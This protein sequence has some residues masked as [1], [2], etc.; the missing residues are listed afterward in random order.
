M[1]SSSLVI[2]SLAFHGALAAG[3]GA[4]RQDAARRS[5]TAISMAE[6]KPKP[7]PKHDTPPPKTPDPP[8]DDHRLKAKAAPPREAKATDAPPPKST[9]PQ[10]AG[11]P[12]G[13]PDFGLSLSGGVGPGGLAIPDGP[14]R[15]AVEAPKAAAPRAPAAQ[16]PVVDDCTEAVVKPKPIN[17]PQPAYTEA[18]RGAG[19][20]GKVRVE[21]TVDAQGAV[22]GVR[23]LSGL[24]YGLDEAALSAARSA[25]FT[26]ATHCGKP[27]EGDVRRLDAV[28]LVK[29]A[30][31]AFALAIA[32]A[33]RRASRSRSR[34][35]P[36]RCLASPNHPSS[37]I[38][39]RHL[40]LRSSARPG[41]AATVVLQL[42][43]G[44]TGTVDRADVKESA[45]LAFD[46]AAAAAARQFVFE[47]AEIDGKPSPIRIL[48]RYA[49]VFT[50]GDADEGQASTA[51]CAITARTRRSPG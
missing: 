29:R 2:M 21:I 33:S 48:Y 1:R 37:H 36:A 49:F 17:V 34:P 43:I 13:M 22:A 45:G 27:T 35:S 20:T 44:A 32:C 41:R 23:L 26:P 18:A 10:S 12:D 4:L 50:A 7:P 11:A 31:V 46:E 25:S 30:A 42:A 6:S 14:R 5:A 40:T 24:G 19:I 39:S 47:P 51:W 38:S 28:L 3:I 16:K 15:E 8:K 9:N